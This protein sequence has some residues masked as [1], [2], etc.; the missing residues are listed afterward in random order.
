VLDL[1]NWVLSKVSLWLLGS[2]R[3]VELLL[4]F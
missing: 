2:Y 4:T 3:D 1:G